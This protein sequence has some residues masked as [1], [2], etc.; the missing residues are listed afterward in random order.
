[1]QKSTTM[2]LGHQGEGDKPGTKLLNRNGKP[3]VVSVAIVHLDMNYI[4]VF[5]IFL[6]A[7]VLM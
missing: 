3:V 5:F 1:M 4:G 2:K 7:L 6:N